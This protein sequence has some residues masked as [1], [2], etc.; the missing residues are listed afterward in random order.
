MT[1]LRHLLREN[2]LTLAFLAGFLL[3]LAGQALSGHAELTAV[4][5]AEGLHP[6]TFT[7]YLFSS[8]F[9]VDVM[10]NWQSEFLQFSLYIIGTVWL[11]QRGSPESKRLDKTG[12]ESDREQR[13]GR[14]A[15][16]DSPRWAGAGGVRQ[17]LYSRSLGTVMLMVFGLSWLAQSVTGRIAFNEEQL[18]QRHD[19]VGWVTYLGSA[20]FWNR[21][22]QNWQ[23]ELLAVAAMAVLSVYLRQRGSPESKPVGAAHDATGVEG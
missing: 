22:L 5:T 16:S 13:V 20:E 23:S 15:R 21:T 18:R 3:S 19:P 12:T 8:A 7:A 10:E 11:L 17:A 4:L 6:P 2:G 9:M 1:R 14:W